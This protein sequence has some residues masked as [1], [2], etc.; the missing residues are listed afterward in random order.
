MLRPSRWPLLLAVFAGVMISAAYINY[1]RGTASTGDLIV[2]FFFGGGAL[3]YADKFQLEEAENY[4]ER[5]NA[6]ERSG[7]LPKMDKREPSPILGKTR[8]AKVMVIQIESA[9]AGYTLTITNDDDSTQ[10]VTLTEADVLAL[11]QSA[12]VVRSSIAARHTRPGADAVVLTPV[13]RLKVEVDIHGTEL[14]MT[15]QAQNGAR[16]AYLLTEEGAL[17]L[18]DQLRGGLGKVAERRPVTH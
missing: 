15:L 11:A 9:E 17:V 8:E 14:H 3:Y 7:D 1:M 16:F 6:F 12:E 4:W 13:D 5:R 2:M 10:Q 18:L